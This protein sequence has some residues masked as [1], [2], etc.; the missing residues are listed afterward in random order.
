[1]ESMA[2]GLAAELR[3][4]TAK[5][6]VRAERSGIVQA[7]IRGRATMAGYMLYLRNLYPVY[8]ALEAALA[9]CGGERRGVGR[10]ARPDLARAPALAADLEAL[11]G[12]SWRAR[13]AL[14]PE[15]TRYAVAVAEAAEGDGAGLIGHAY[16]RYLGDL[17]GAQVLKPIVQRSLGLEE[18][19]MRFYAFPAITD[20]SA[21]K[22][23]FRDDLDAAGEEIASPDAVLDAAVAAF[24]HTILVSEA[25]AARA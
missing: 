8:A 18:G 20:L 10:F 25:I 6:H 14:L 13:V 2:T 24:E 21:T 1:M 11:A 16:A 4:A 5:A 7:M 23:G 19:A 12:A 17:S 22:N 9:A 15:A 3:A